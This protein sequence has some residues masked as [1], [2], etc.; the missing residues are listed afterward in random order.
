MGLTRRGFLTGGAAAVAFPDQA[1]AGRAG[2]DHLFD[3]FKE[4]SPN[5][6]KKPFQGF[7]DLTPLWGRERYAAVYF[8]AAHEIY[9]GCAN[10]FGEI[11]HAISFGGD[12]E[13]FIPVFAIAQPHP[14][15]PDTKVLDAFRELQQEFPEAKVLMHEDVSH[16]QRL[17]VLAG[18][19]FEHSG[20]RVTGHGRN[21]L[22]FRE[23]GH[24]LL[25]GRG[26][27]GR[28]LDVPDFVGMLN[29]GN[30]EASLHSD[31]RV[32]PNLKD[33][34]SGLD[35]GEMHARFG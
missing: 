13:R 21:M 28:T 24:Q 3:G 20:G 15:D 29:R 1:L 33:R 18:T 5:G 22:V 4:L 32:H 16:V 30:F 26:A 31:M 2:L 17:S 25:F 14:N 12:G 10:D 8:G 35:W 6:E 7:G 11:A 19:L 23:D 27:K 9:E 34:L